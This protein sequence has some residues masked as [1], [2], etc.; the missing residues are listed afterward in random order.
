MRALASFIFISLDGFYE[1]P[2]GEPTGPTQRE[3]S[4]ISRVRSLD[5][6]DLLAFGR[7]TYD[8]MAAHW[9]TEKA[10]ANDP[11]LTSRMNTKDKLVFSTSCQRRTG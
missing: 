7:R 9:P 4:T 11:A 8:H 6:A 1:G 10:K 3:S 2:H 5:K